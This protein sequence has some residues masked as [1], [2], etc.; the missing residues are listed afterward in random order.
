MIVKKHFFLHTTS[1]IVK[2][3]PFKQASKFVTVWEK[4]GQD[5]NWIF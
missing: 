4:Q 5:R 1:P 2:I 3:L